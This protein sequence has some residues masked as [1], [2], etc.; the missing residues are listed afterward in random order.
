MS[1]CLLPHPDDRP[2]FDEI[3]LRL[4]RLDV[5]NVEPDTIKKSAKDK[6][7]ERNASLLLD[8]FPK[9]IA[10]ALRDGRKVEPE[11]HEM[12]TIFFSDIVGFTNISGQLSPLKV[13]DMLHRL[14]LRFDSLSEKHEVFKVSF[15]LK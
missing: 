1:D 10:E 11:H 15:N 4:K 3:D 14:Y 12:T 6:E 5:V 9:H 8:V 7:A 13:A 2:T